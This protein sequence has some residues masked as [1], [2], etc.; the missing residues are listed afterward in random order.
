MSCRSI[1]INND[2]TSCHFRYSSQSSGVLSNRRTGTSKVDSD[3]GKKLYLISLSR[4]DH[5]VER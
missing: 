2:F 3:D 1:I 4:K 5:A